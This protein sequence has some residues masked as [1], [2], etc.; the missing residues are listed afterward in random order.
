MSGFSNSNRNT[1]YLDNPNNRLVR[2]YIDA[3]KSNQNCKVFVL[4]NVPQIL[5]AGDGQFKDEILDELKEFEIQY[6]VLNAE[7]SDLPNRVKGQYLL[8]LK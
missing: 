5:S 3:V 1:N 8:D 2:E 7:T 4:E 6:G